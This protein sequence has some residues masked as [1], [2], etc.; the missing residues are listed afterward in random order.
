MA[1]PQVQAPSSSAG[2]GWAGSVRIQGPPNLSCRSYKIGKADNELGIFAGKYV[3]EQTRRSH[4]Q[5]G[6]PIVTREASDGR[7]LEAVRFRLHPSLIAGW[8]PAAAGKLFRPRASHSD[9]VQRVA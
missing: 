6:Q 8:P 7:I 2:G 3:C 5:E 9:K 1:L 4:F